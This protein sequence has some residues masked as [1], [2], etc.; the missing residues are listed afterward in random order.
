M[1]ENNATYV[2]VHAHEQPDVDDVPIG[3]MDVIAGFGIEHHHT[4]LLSLLRKQNHWY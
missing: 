1:I 4:I 2:E 3:L